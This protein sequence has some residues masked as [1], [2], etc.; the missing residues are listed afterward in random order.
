[1]KF[2]AISGSLR[3]AS[4]NTSLLREAAKLVPSDV[5]MDV[6]TLS[7]FPMLDPDTLEGGFPEQVDKLAKQVKAADA[8]VLASPEFNYSVTAVMKNIIDW[9]SIHPEAPLKH[10]PVAIMS[11]SPSGLGGARAQ[12]QLRQMLIY[13]DS[14]VLGVPEVMVGNAFE[15]FNDQGELTDE[16]SKDLIKQQMAALKD[17]CKC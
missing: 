3:K 17:L 6:Q 9:L 16:T 1:M 5:Q 11:A 12:Y 10:K 15:R 8:L 2:L 14:K 7:G 13:P 4:L